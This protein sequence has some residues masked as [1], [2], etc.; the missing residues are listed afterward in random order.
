MTHADKPH[1]D[2]L[3]ALLREARDMLDHPEGCDTFPSFRHCPACQLEARIDAALTVA[4]AAST[5]RG[6][7]QAALRTWHQ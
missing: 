1:Y 7:A 4:A 6:Y 3:A 5:A 2:N